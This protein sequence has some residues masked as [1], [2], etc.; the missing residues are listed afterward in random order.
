MIRAFEV[1]FRRAPRNAGRWAGWLL[2]VVACAVL[3]WLADGHAAVTEAHALAQEAHD[4]GAQ[5]LRARQPASDTARADAQTLTELRRV[6]LVI[7]QLTVPWDGLFQA[8]EAADAKGL[9]VLSLTPSALD[10]TLRLGGEARNVGD[11]LSYVERLVA[12]PTLGAVHLQ[13]YNTVQREGASVIGFTLAASWRA[14][15]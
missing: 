11:V 10:R 3:A 9:G 1:D 8:V 7:D 12:Q 4:F 15:P 5:R 6:N 13:G 2:L 14:Q